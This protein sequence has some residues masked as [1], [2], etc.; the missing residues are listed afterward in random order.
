MDAPSYSLIDR[1]VGWLNPAAGLRRALARRSLAK[2]RAYEGANVGAD[3]WVPRRQGASANAD[4][5]ADAPM[6]RARARSLVQNNP[7]AAKALNC[8]VSNVI[9]EGIMPSSR[10]TDEKTRT[11]LDALW[12]QML[13]V[14]DADGGTDLHG[15]VAQAYRAMEQ[16]GEVLVRLRTR[17]PE[18]GLPVPLQ[19][20][21]LEIDYLDSTKSGDLKNGGRIISG[22]EFDALGRVAAYWLRDTHPGDSA[23]ASIKAGTTSRRH[24]ARNII[25]LFAPDRPGQARGITRFAAVIARLRDLAIY[26]DAE[27]ARKQNEALM[28]VFIS[29]D[30]TDFAVPGA[31]ESASAAA[32][33]ASALGELGSLKPGAILATNGQSVTVAAPQAAPGYENYIRSQ[34]YAVAAGTGVTYEMLTGD[35]SQV[36]DRMARVGMMEFRRGAEQRQWHV[37]IPRLLSRLWIAFVDAAVLGGKIPRPDYAVEWTTP[38]WD[39]INPVQ[40]VQADADEI[41]AGLASP[42]EK[43]RKRGYQP[44]AVFKEIGDDFAKLK[45]SGALEY[46][47]F[48]SKKAPGAEAKPADPPPEPAKPK[49]DEGEL[50]VRAVESVGNRFAETV[51]AMPVPE[52]HFHAGDTHVAATEVRNEITVPPASTPDIHVAAPDVRIDNHVNVP[53]AAAPIV[54]VDVAAPNVRV[55]NTVPAS[56]EITIVS[57]PDRVTETSVERDAKGNIKKST[58][59]EKDAE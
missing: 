17:R 53:E 48:L 31:G 9:G 33:R 44:E 25:H 18:D 20:Q 56:S 30:G 40:D 49:R 58:Q 36:N 5:R 23:F 46:L 2:V 28:S 27:L 15:L 50:I 47:A 51:R 6:L 7:Y 43:L 19:I 4:H 42:S 11:T 37:I 3:G 16:D 21:L 34:L 45:A 1:A 38:K 57:M 35:L 41:A 22:I 59:V 26:E 29:G 39:Y 13:G 32:S 52:Y 12:A 24:E 8:L 55:E 54:N 14:I 10:A